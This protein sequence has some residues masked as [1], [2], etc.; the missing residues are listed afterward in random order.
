MK[1]QTQQ[2]KTEPTKYKVI[3]C[4]KCGVLSPITNEFIT[5]WVAGQHTHG[6][7]THKLSIREVTGD[8]QLS[9]KAKL[10]FLIGQMEYKR[11]F[12]QEET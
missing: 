6:R 8:T 11:L 3:Y 1:M 4:S 5:G 9:P 2:T 10:S 12:E 7:S